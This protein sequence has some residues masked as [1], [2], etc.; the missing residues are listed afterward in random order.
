[1][2]GLST[3]MRE[4][5]VTTVLDAIPDVRYIYPSPT[6]WPFVAALS[7]GGWLLWSIYSLPGTLW[8]MIP[9][10]VAFA[11]WYWPRKKEA[12]E[13]LKLEKRPPD[14]GR[15]SIPATVAATHRNGA[16]DVA[17]L[18][19]FGFGHRSLM[20]WGNA[21]MIAIEGTAFAFMIVIYFYLRSLSDTPPGVNPTPSLLWGTVNLVIILASAIPNILTNRAAIAQDRRK[22][23]IGLIVCS[24]MTLA[25]C[26]VRALEFTALNVRWD[27]SAYGSVIWT[28]LG[29]HTFNL[30]TDC[31]DTLVLTAVMFKNPIEGKRYVDIAENAGYWDFIVLSWIPIYAL[32][33]WAPSF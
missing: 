33:Y 32:I 26:G 11:A 3:R 15:A 28:F 1:M 23:R 5:L 30:I 14:H 16:L 4:G 29:L 2:I 27:E 8:G 6:I 24:I 9:P 10:A 18:P 20:W 17:D 25:L 12:I 7:V 21:G 13:E 22:V 19:S 31:A